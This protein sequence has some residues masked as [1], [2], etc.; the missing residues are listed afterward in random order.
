[1]LHLEEEEGDNSASS[2]VIRFGD[3]A[4]EPTLSSETRMMVY[5]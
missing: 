4:R 2:D 5:E 1:M 3:D